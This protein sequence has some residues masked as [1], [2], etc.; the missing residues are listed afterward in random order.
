MAMSRKWLEE[1]RQFLIDLIIALTIFSF[2]YFL[3]GK[4][5]SLVVFVAIFLAVVEIGA[6]KRKNE[7][8]EWYINELNENIFDQSQFKR[9]KES[10][11]DFHNV[12]EAMES[13]GIRIDFSA[14]RIKECLNAH[15]VVDSDLERKF[16]EKGKYSIWFTGYASWVP[17]PVIEMIFKSR[18]LV[19]IKPSDDIEPAYMGIIN[20]CK[21][22]VPT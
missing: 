10:S 6:L 14:R 3:F 4:D 9:R 1:I 8:L 17:Y 18:K 13:G 12:L 16:Q 19:I 5:I 20:Q 11:K 2:V 15:G 7:K 22:K 21:K